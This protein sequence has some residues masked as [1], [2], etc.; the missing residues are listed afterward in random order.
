MH[1]IVLSL[2]LFNF[3]TVEPSILSAQDNIRDLVVRIHAVH[4][5]PDVLRPWTKNSPQQ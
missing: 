5:T 3:L 4:H 1:R 2:L